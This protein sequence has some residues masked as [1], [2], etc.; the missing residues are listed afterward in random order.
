MNTTKPNTTIKNRTIN[1]IIEHWAQKGKKILSRAK[2]YGRQSFQ[3][4][5]RLSQMKKFPCLIMPM[6]KKCQKKLIN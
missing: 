6:S 4:L 5:V 1:V 3:N 2:N